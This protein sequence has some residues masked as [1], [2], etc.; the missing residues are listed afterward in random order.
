MKQMLEDIKLV[1]LGIQHEFVALND[2]LKQNMAS[3]P[4]VSSS[5]KLYADPGG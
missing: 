4:H 2:I 1:Q 3:L 5:V